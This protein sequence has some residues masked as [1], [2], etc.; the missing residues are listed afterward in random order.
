MPSHLSGS[1]N[2][3]ELLSRIAP[4]LVLLLTH[5]LVWFAGSAFK[6]VRIE[7]DGE[8]AFNDA[9]MRMAKQ[10]VDD[11]KEIDR[12]R[13]LLFDYSGPLRGVRD[14]KPVDAT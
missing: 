13:G 14:N 7:R 5:V 4:L 10:K 2:S 12:L 1:R 9:L 3:M 6:K 8:R 11:E